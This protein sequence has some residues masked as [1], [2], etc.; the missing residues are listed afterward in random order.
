M[1]RKS[2]L[3]QIE[4]VILRRYFFLSGKSSWHVSAIVGETATERIGN[5]SE[6]ATDVFNIWF[7]ASVLRVSVIDLEESLQPVASKKQNNPRVKNAF[8]LA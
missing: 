3:F 7:S 4:Y 8:I 6:V 2:S 1:H 5:S